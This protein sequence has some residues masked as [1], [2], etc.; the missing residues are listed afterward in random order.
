MNSL[1]NAHFFPLS[2]QGNIYT[3]T[4]LHLAN[5]ANKLLVASLRREVICFEYQE[6]ATGILVPT[7]KEISF[8]YL[9]SKYL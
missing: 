7:A 5:G 3:L 8:T 9:P 2:S 4:S 6:N 1:Q